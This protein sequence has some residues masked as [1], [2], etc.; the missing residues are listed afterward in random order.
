[1]RC[2]VTVAEKQSISKAARELYISQ[3]AMSAHMNAI[4]SELGAQ[5]LVRGRQTHLTSVGEVVLHGFRDI[6][7]AYEQ[8][9]SD[10]VDA[11]ER[12]YG[13]LT[14]G[15]HGPVNWLG[16]ADLLAEFRRKHPES[17]LHVLIDTWANLLLQ[18]Q[19]GAI[20][21]AF[22]EL[23]EVEGL[24]DL[25]WELVKEEPVC[26][27]LP[28]DHPLAKR[29]SVSV[30]DVADEVMLFPDARISPR[31]FHALHDSFRNAGMKVENVGSG[32][33]YEATITLVISGSGISCMPA[34]LHS[35]HGDTVACVPFSDLETHMRYGIVWSRKQV[36]AL[37]SACASFMCSHIQ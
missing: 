8:L 23:S 11:Q 13:S 30:R 12:E 19:E 15:F 3:P 1:M 25:S 35:G 37:A 6:L 22:I 24:T 29:A 27:V 16:V 33:H 14:V 18:L 5:L 9:E 28:R 4:E 31:F 26:A 17:Q 7:A 10:V 34:S 20:D 21:L 32:N 36:N 2:F